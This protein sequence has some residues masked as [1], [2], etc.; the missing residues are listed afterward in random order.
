MYVY[1]I[2]KFFWLCIIKPP[3]P[4]F[5]VPSLFPAATMFSISTAPF[6]SVYQFQNGGVNVA[7]GQQAGGEEWG[8]GVCMYIIHMYMYICQCVSRAIWRKSQTY[9]LAT[10]QKRAEGEAR[11]GEAGGR[12]ARKKHGKMAD[13]A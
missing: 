12:G 6:S 1:G 3:L 9:W 13:M 5:V 4:Q 8:V 10:D 11:G 2:S 7:K